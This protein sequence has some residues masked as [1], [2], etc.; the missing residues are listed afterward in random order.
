METLF[1]KIGYEF[2]NQ[3][4]LEQAL[5]HSSY[6]NEAPQ[7]GI[8]DNERLEF[9]GDA[10]LDLAISHILMESFSHAREGELS[11]YRS[12]LVN[13]ETL[14]RIAKSIELGSYIKHGKGE[15]LSG[16][17]DK[18]SILA[19]AFEALIGAIYLDAGFKKTREV[20]ERLFSSILDRIDGEVKDYKTLL[21][22]YTQ[23][24][25]RARP[26]YRVLEEIGP[27][28]D[29]TFT[30]GVMLNGKMISKGVGKSKKEAEQMGAREAYNWL[31][32]EKDLT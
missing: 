27:P 28:H 22:E 6:V 26:Q 13:E 4:L 29:R 8:S 16:G 31:K 25:F 1:H 11:R 2:K 14:F 12:A 20:V 30:V 7:D 21:Q 18:P 9:L 24:K 15:E 3:A 32:K 10:V 23:D 5:L 19:D 17:R